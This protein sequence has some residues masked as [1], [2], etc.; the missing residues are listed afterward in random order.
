[1]NLA[2]LQE[3]LFSLGGY[4]NIFLSSNKSLKKIV[5]KEEDHYEVKYVLSEGKYTVAEMTTTTT[6]DLGV[7][8]IEGIE[9]VDKSN[10]LG[11]KDLLIN[12]FKQN[13]HLQAFTGTSL[14]SAKGFWTRLNVTFS[15]NIY[16]FILH[17]DK[18]LNEF[19]K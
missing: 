5:T 3:A 11:C 1:M 4:K 15:P 19:D 14:T 10:D 9:R 13:P 7:E 12:V 2:R 18:F 17:K 8:Y 6:E 16:D